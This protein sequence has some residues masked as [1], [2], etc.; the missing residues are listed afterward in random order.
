MRRTTYAGLV[1]EKYLDQEVCLKGWVQKRRNLGNL[2]FIDLRDIEG[3]VQL[4]FSQEFNPEALKVA[5][6]LRS[7]YVIEVKGKVVARGEKA[8]NPNMRTGKVEV[9][10][11]DIE[12]LNK[13][14]T[15]PFDIADDINASDDLRL[16]YRYLDL[17]RPE[18]QKALMIRNRITQTVH[19]YLD[20]NHFL[21]I[22]TPYLTR[23]TP[24]G[25]RD[26]LV[27]SRV[28]PGHFYAL[29]QSPQLFKQ[30][31]MGA[32]YDRYY[33][34][35]RCF[36]DEDLRGDR[37]P[38]FTQIDIETSFMSAEEIQEMTEGLLK[39]VM[40]ETLDVDIK[41]PIQRITWNEA[42][43]RFGSD[44]PDI[45]FGMELKDMS[46]AVQ[47]A[48]FKVFDMTLEN[49]GQVKAI[50]VPGGADKYSRKQIE[51]KQEYIKRFGAK[52]LAWVKVTD[53]GL[54]GPIAK[55]FTERAEDIKAAAEAKSGDLI[56]FV[57]SN[58]KVVADSLG[59]LRVAIAKEMD[60]INKDEF[61]F[62]WVVDWPLFEY[63][64]EFDRYIA[65]HHP[66][67][68]PNEEDLDLLETDPH[69]C[70][71]Q[72]YDIVLNGYE[73]GGG[74]IRIHRRDIQEAMFKAL[75]FTKEKA[76][77]QFGWFMDALDFG[78]PPHGGLA[79]GLDRF[80]M[81]L[82]GKD[83]IRE[84][85]AFPKNSKASEP[86]THAPSTVAPKQLDELYLKTDVPEEDE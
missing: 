63:S 25:A 7:E 71:A 56:L 66:F 11:S 48:G 13:A 17:R 21:D 79:L 31:L 49:G 52:G 29:P 10:V 68:M 44:K 32:G 22:E 23:S 4:V 59:Y 76:E 69:K 36:R 2:I 45:R 73:L 78:F 55:F 6:Q 86:L 47:N 28:Y 62:I 60:M 24:E 30:L 75:G 85:I 3:I 38:E 42:M 26:Y 51:E 19:S 12:I 84:V 77:E 43:D 34:I 83:N 54:T 82:A 40:K 1:D 64:E 8:I 41:T 67:T 72:S 15:T 53:D 33:Q 27:P 57:A 37:Q 70:H 74:S 65:A 81:L 61:A 35:A 14:K 9:E 18:M 20:E 16:Q 46:S 5:E 50:T 39:R 58:R 80:A